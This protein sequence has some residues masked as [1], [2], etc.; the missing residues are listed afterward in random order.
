M[1]QTGMALE[2]V[3]R[4]PAEGPALF[5]LTDTLGLGYRDVPCVAYIEVQG[6]GRTIPAKWTEKEVSEMEATFRDDLEFDG[7]NVHF[8]RLSPLSRASREPF[9]WRLEVTDPGMEDDEDELAVTTRPNQTPSRYR[10]AR[11]DASI[12]TM[13]NTIEST[14]GLPEGCVQIVYPSGQRARRDASVRTIRKQWDAG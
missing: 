12:P 10:R 11:S 2:A 9:M 13:I 5:D 8:V 4:N 1:N 6:K 7:F 14:F 3:Y